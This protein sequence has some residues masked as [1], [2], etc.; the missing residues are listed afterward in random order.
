MDVAAGLVQLAGARQ[1]VAEHSWVA[2][3]AAVLVLA[4]PASFVHSPTFL[5]AS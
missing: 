3:P 5:L 4:Y 2:C 1:A